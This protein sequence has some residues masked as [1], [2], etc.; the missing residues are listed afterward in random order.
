MIKP[1][2]TSQ[3][4]IH[5]SLGDAPDVTMPKFHLTIWED[6]PDIKASTMHISQHLREEW[7]KGIDAFTSGQWDAAATSFRYFSE[8]HNPPKCDGPARH[9][10]A[11][12]QRFD[13][14]PPPHWKGYRT[15]TS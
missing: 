11:Q 7:K 3:V 5:T 1:K 2:R 15:I 13:F 6:D 12:M 9:L 10:L 8:N 4:K 14:K